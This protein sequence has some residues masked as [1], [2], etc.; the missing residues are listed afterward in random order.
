M[1]AVFVDAGLAGINT[2]K[3]YPPV[4][5]TRCSDLQ[6]S[7]TVLLAYVSSSS[8][9]PDPR[10]A[11]SAAEITDPSA[12]AAWVMGPPGEAVTT[13]AKALMLHH[14]VWSTD[15]KCTANYTGRRS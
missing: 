10:A 5:N 3:R 7:P 12:S 2:L 1:H 9:V 6:T 13:T 4:K 14:V 11:T 8:A 15:S